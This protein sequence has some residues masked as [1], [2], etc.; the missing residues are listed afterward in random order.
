ML[1]VKGNNATCWKN[2]VPQC[3]VLSSFDHIFK[4][5]SICVEVLAQSVQRF[6]WRH[7]GVSGR[8][9]PAVGGVERL[10]VGGTDA[11]SWKDRPWDR[12][13]GTRS[14]SENV[15]QSRHWAVTRVKSSKTIECQVSRKLI[16]TLWTP[17]PAKNRLFSHRL[18]EMGK[19]E[20]TMVR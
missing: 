13:T 4:E 5:V 15:A 11:V 20:L 14:L 10:A 12:P 8:G 1:F 3:A 2:I 16:W 6:G 19:W 9:L 7:W 18:G 17:F